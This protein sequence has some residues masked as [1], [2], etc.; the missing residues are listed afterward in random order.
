MKFS[1]KGSKNY[2]A[3]SKCRIVIIMGLKENRCEGKMEKEKD[4]KLDKEK[5]SAK[6]IELIAKASELPM[7]QVNR[8][9][10]LRKTFKGDPN[11]EVILEK[12]PQAVYTVESLRKKANSI[13]NGSTGKTA[14]ASF[15][16][17][18]PSN[19]GVALAA[20]GVDITQYFGFSI[21]LAQKISYLFG[22]EEFKELSSE[23]AQAKIMLLLGTM[24]GVETAKNGLV[25]AVVIAGEAV[26]KHVA[27]KPL[28]KTAWFPIIKRVAWEIGQ[29]VTKQTVKD[30]I[31]K[32]FSVL[33]AF[34]SGGITFVS[35]RPLG[36]NLANVYVDI[37][38]GKYDVEMVMR[39]DFIKP[40]ES[41]IVD[42]EYEVV[43]EII[44]EDDEY[45]FNLDLE[46]IDEKN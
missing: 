27:A 28:T 5:L 22:A 43:D 15:L 45:V 10:F 40:E 16:S 17:G 41:N 11:I 46:E 44:E 29:K 8:E 1:K 13:I 39:D 33:G 42:V 25:R 32:G 24:Y 18:L 36:H 37:L 14:V 6:T 4:K 19:P 30:A 20:A 9:E 35:F 2:F 26:A 21:N 7:V 23:E 38:N 3:L 31:T 34:V 12:G